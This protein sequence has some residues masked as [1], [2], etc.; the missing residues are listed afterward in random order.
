MDREEG[1]DVLSRGAWLRDTP[2]DFRDALLS[3]CRWERLEAGALIQTGSGE[4]VEMT[5][6]ASG[7]MELRSVV[8]RADTPIMHFARPVFWLSFSRIIS[9]RRSNRVEATAK[10]T[11]W[12]ARASQAAVRKLLDERPDWWRYMLLPAL[13]Y[14]DIALD[15]AADLLMA[16]S[17][18]RCAAVLLRLSARRFADSDDPE[19][20]DLSITQEDLAGAA[21][22]SRSSVRTMLGRLAARGLIEQ[23][24]GGIVVRAPAALRAFVDEG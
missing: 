17:E 10:T 13:F 3:I 4:D 6:L 12:L 15:I 2:A 23:G 8:G 9:Q 7:V 14:G 20:V 22:L 24:Y 21:N 1:M 11:V 18:R 19:P 5:G 16:D